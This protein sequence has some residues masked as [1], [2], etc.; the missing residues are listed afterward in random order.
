MAITL[1]EELRCLIP[2]ERVLDGFEDRLVHGYDAT[3]ELRIPDVVV[4]VLSTAEIAAIMEFAFA[5]GVPVVPRGAGTGFSGGSQEEEPA[6][7]GHWKA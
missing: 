7:S 5:A 3:R 2:R 4:K 6:C 1:A